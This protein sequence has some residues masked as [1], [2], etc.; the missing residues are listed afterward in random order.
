[1]KRRADTVTQRSRA[2][3]RL[4]SL[5]TDNTDNNKAFIKQCLFSEENYKKCV[6]H[7]VRAPHARLSIT[8]ALCDLQLTQRHSL[9]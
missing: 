6:I 7:S 8:T 4:E 1:M 3:L 5:T 2:D 9:T